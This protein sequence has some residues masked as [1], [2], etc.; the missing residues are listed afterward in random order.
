MAWRRRPA[1]AKFKSGE[2][3]LFDDYSTVV[4]NLPRDPDVLTAVAELHAARPN[5]TELDLSSQG[6][7]DAKLAA[8]I[9]KAPA[10]TTKLAAVMTGD[11]VR[12]IGMDA[13]DPNA[14]AAMILPRAMAVAATAEMDPNVGATLRGPEEKEVSRLQQLVVAG[15]HRNRSAKA[16]LLIGVSGD[17]DALAS[18]RCLGQA[19]TVQVRWCGAAP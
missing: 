13:V 7:D 6:L 3:G 8:A 11:W 5:M 9:E 2:G 19:G 15:L 14:V 18:K 12:V 10:G 4:M 1:V 17:P 16:F